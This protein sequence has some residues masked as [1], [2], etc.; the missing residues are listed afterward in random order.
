MYLICIPLKHQASRAADAR[1]GRAAIAEAAN[2][3]WWDQEGVPAESPDLSWDDGDMG[4]GSPP[5][6]ST[7][8]TSAPKSAIT[9][10]ATG[11][12]IKLAAS[13]T[14]RPLSRAASDISRTRARW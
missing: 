9:V 5:G 11:P 1:T 3:L 10:A 7:L 13:M 2:T 8:I 14:F 6:A 4:L 12:A